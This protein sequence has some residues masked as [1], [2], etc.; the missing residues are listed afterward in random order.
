MRKRSIGQWLALLGNL[1][2]CTGLILNGFE[3]ISQ[4]GLRIIAVTGVVID[5]A[6]LFFIWKK[7]EF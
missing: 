2:V 5:F 1:V 7:K 4:T 3:L 6:A